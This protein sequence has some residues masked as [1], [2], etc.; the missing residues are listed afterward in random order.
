MYMDKEGQTLATEIF[1]ELKSSARRW[2]IA[3]LVMCGIEIATVAG[4]IWYL[5]LPTDYEQVAIENDEGNANYIGGSVG[6]N[7]NNMQP[8]EQITE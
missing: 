4:F 7:L 1:S 3:F 8:V 2:F 6:G 5:S